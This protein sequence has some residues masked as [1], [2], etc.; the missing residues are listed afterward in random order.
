MN[1]IAATKKLLMDKI[2]EIALNK[3]LY[4]RNP[5]KDFSRNRKITFSDVIA[6]QISMESGS[7]RSELLEYFSYSPDLPTTSAFTQQRDKIYS[8]AFK[9]LF[10]TFTSALNTSYKADELNIYAV[11]GTKSN[12]P[13]LS[14]T[15]ED[16]TY[17]S[18]ED[19]RNYYQMHIDAIFDLKKQ[20]YVGAEF[21]PRKKN[22]ERKAF[23]SM[24]EQLD[25]PD[26]SLFI[27]DRGYEGYALMAH[28]S[29][30]NKYFVIRAKDRKNGGIIK[31][32]D[33][34]NS[35]QFDFI[36]DKIFVHKMR[37]AYQGNEDRYHVT[38]K[39]DSPYFLNK[40]RKEYHMSFRVV[41]FQLDNGSYECLLTNL[42]S[43]Q[44]DINAL[45][46]I[47]HM[48]WGIETS[49]RYLKHTVGLL[50][51]HSKKLDSIK[52][53]IWSRLIMFNFC[54]EIGRIVP[55]KEKTNKYSYIKNYTNLVLICRRILISVSFEIADIVA[56]ITRALSPVRPGR[57]NPRN[58]NRQ[59]PIS[60]T[61][62]K[63]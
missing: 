40:K 21:C 30:E 48:R 22:N 1:T 37:K 56:L 18:R 32:I 33:I 2:Q 63:R 14:D 5:G 52:Q 51:F 41:R 7:I 54:S 31:G 11:D 55:H 25:F 4:V 16:Y 29:S 58:K 15:D 12:I 50:D 45:K 57:S 17:F 19:Q 3:D 35:E 47:Y 60:F 34:P 53:E 61:Y 28:I 26:K 46:E 23:H 59:R 24:F 44:F 36:Y 27:F 62:R 9:D 42:P 8:T 43:Q 49:F 6:N 13:T 38:H 39:T 10:Y 20:I